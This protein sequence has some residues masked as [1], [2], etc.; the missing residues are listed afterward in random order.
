MWHFH[1][2][3]SV[4]FTWKHHTGEATACISTPTTMHCH[5]VTE[6]GSL[7]FP[8]TQCPWWSK[9]TVKNWEWLN[10]SRW[11]RAVTNIHQ[12][13]LYFPHPF[14]IRQ[15]IFFSTFFG[16]THFVHSRK[17][18]LLALWLQGIILFLWWLLSSG[19]WVAWQWINMSRN[20]CWYIEN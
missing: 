7:R 3:Q 14:P 1:I 18:C 12:K 11:H 19:N 9:I 10:Q 16:R 2:P 5:P 4:R 17:L 8:G 15:E 13:I 6:D 20:K